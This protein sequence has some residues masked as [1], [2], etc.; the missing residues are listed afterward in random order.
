MS[1][2]RFV[3]SDRRARSAWAWLGAAI[4]VGVVVAAAATVI[5]GRDPVRSPRSFRLFAHEAAGHSALV[6]RKWRIDL[7]N[8]PMGLITAAAVCGDEAYFLELV[9]ARVHKISLSQQRRV[10]SFGGFQDPV[11][12]G[13]DCA[14]SL[15]VV[16]QRGVVVVDS[17]SGRIRE[18]FA[19]PFTFVNAPAAATFDPLNQSLYVQG[20]WT[21]SKSDW[22]RKSLD[23]LYEGDTIGYAMDLRTGCDDARG[24]RRGTRMLEL[25]AELPR[26]AARKSAPA[27]QRVLAGRACHRHPRRRL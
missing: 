25:V 20:L 12:L 18:S 26:R 24:Q 2:H 3:S 5:S 11:G 1:N 21:A 22:K 15:Y 4:T 9:Q 17:G 14:G 10:A 6:D 23:E 27:G 13:A 8:A 19:K 7:D 16:E